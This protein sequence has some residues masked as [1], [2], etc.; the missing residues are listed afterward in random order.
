MGERFG[1]MGMFSISFCS[2]SY[3]NTCIFQNSNCI[4]KTSDFIMNKLCL[5][6]SV[7]F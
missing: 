2:D 4:L 6:K 3:M 7:F 5:I 1:V